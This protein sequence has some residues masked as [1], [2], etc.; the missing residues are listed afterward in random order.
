MPRGLDIRAPHIEA[1][2]AR[3]HG[4]EETRIRHVLKAL[5]CTRNASLRESWVERLQLARSRVSL[6]GL[7]LSVCGSDSIDASTGVNDCLLAAMDLAL[8][9]GDL[10]AAE[11]VARECVALA[12][13]RCSHA[14]RDLEEALSEADSISTCLA[15]ASDFSAGHCVPVMPA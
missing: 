6:L 12:D 3:A 1:P 13:A 9:N 14:W 15:G 8:S 2:L 10:D 4:A 5:Q 7:M 11:A